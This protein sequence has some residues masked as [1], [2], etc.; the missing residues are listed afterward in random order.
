MAPHPG[1]RETLIPWEIEFRC[2]LSPEIWREAPF[3]FSA[4]KKGFL[5][6]LLRL[7]FQVGPF[8]TI[9]LLAP[10]T[11][12]L[13]VEHFLRYRSNQI[14][15]CFSFISMTFFPQ[16][17]FKCSYVL[18]AMINEGEIKIY[19]IVFARK[20]LNV[21]WGFVLINS[22]SRLNSILVINF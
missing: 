10:S 14:T 8:P 13:H 16:Q 18:G 17:T 3:S 2:N 12:L 22:G 21:Q 20:I 11:I 15:I 1:R 4:S 6:R 5:Y 9:L 7:G 19:N